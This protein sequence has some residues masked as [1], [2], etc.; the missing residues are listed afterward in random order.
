MAEIL[1]VKV[2]GTSRNAHI[3]TLR[4]YAMQDL[5]ALSDARLYTMSAL[6]MSIS[7]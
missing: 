5:L 6:Q 4:A 2:L 3:S 1:S 7:K